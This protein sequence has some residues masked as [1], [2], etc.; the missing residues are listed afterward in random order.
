[1]KTR[2]KQG[3][4]HRVYSYIPLTEYVTKIACINK[5]ER[6]SLKESS[7]ASAG[8][9]FDFPL[10]AYEKRYCI[11]HEKRLEK[12]MKRLSSILSFVSAIRIQVSL[13]NN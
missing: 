3:I 6:E 12:G 10:L 13:S 7:I 8:K 2:L 11:L 9:V 1:M 5:K 4:R